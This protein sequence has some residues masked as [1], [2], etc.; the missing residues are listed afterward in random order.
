MRFLYLFLYIL[1]YRI[2]FF[3]ELN[4]SIYKPEDLKDLDLCY[5]LRTLKVNISKSTLRNLL[6]EIMQNLAEE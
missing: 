1:G 5:L 3:A 2:K 4:K 6:L